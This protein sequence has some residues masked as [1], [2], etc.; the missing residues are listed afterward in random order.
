MNHNTPDDVVSFPTDHAT[1]DRVIYVVARDILSLER[2]DL[3]LDNFLVAVWGGR[4]LVLVCVVAFGLMGVI[5]SYLATPRY[6]AKTLLAPVTR[7]EMTGLE[8]QLGN[9]GLLTSLA[10]IS[11]GGGGDTAA[12][13]GVLKSR[14][15]A[16]K[17]IEDHNLLHVLLWKDWDT[18]AGRWKE[19]DPEQQPDIR[20][21]IAYFDRRVLFVS[22]DMKTGLVTVSIRWK[23]PGVAAKWANTIVDQLNAQMR[24][25]ALTEGEANVEYLQ[26]EMASTKQMSVQ[27]AIARLVESELQRVMVAESTREFAFRVIDHAEV[28]KGRSWPR[29][30]ISGALGVIMGGLLGLMA[31]FMKTLLKRRLQ[32]G[33]PVQ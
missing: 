12:S 2:R 21:A 28:P 1:R 31:A 5:Y 3:G 24:A 13:L 14:D 7:N 8:G 26:R 19:S 23:D 10:G 29:P 4:W 32:L 22:Q 18:K 15:F 33:H 16:R 17:F 6:D 20:D 11:L 27:A 9:L 25:R 30:G